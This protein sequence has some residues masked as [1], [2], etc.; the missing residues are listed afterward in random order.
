[1]KWTKYKGRDALVNKIQTILFFR[2][3]EKRY[4]KLMR[5]LIFYEVLSRED[6]IL[7]SMNKVVSEQWM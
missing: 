4:Y 6:E 2:L 7:E 1:M 3:I 5:T